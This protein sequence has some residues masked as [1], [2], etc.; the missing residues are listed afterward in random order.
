MPASERNSSGR[1]CCCGA[2]E[3]VL[4]LVTT[5]CY[6]AKVSLSV[7][8]WWGELATIGLSLSLP[9]TLLA[10]QLPL[11][12]SPWTHALWLVLF[13]WEALWLLQAWAMLCRQ[14]TPRIVFP[15]FYPAFSLACLLHIG[16]LYAWG[17]HQLELAL[18]LGALLSL[19]LLACVAMLTTHLYCIRG[20]LKYFYTC[21]FWLTRLLVLN[22]SVAYATWSTILTLYALAT[23]LVGSAGVAAATASTILLSLLSSLVLTYFLLENSILDPLLRYVFTVYPVDSLLGYVFTVY[24]VDRYVLGCPL[25]HTPCM[26]SLCTLLSSEPPGMCLL[27]TLLSSGC[28]LVS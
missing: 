12:P 9:S 25:N 28:L 23:V 20:N 27:C 16:W 15:G 21:T 18:A 22:A 10:P 24:P 11:S 1:K 6:A 4:V 19:C 3:V 13:A 26:C 8:A 17:R 2:F 14:H 7:Y 5:L